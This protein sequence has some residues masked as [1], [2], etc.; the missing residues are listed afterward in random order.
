VDELYDAIIVRPVFAFADF[1]ARLFDPYVVDGSV[2]GVGALV[3]ALSDGWRR[4]QTGNLQ[5][6]ALSFVAGALLLLGYYVAR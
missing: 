6:V 1:G 4:F 2:N 3:R 5:H